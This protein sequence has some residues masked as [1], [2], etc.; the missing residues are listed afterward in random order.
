MQ[1]DE[2]PV[3]EVLLARDHPRD[4]VAM[5]LRAGA[6][7]TVRPGAYVAA[8]PELPPHAGRRR[9]A[10]AHIAA[11]REQL[12]VDV[13]VTHQSAALLWGLPLVVPSGPTHV[14]QQHHPGRNCADDV[15]R[16]VLQLAPHEVTEH[17]GFRTTTLERTVVDCA[18]SLPPRQAL[19]LA[20]AALHVGADAAAVRRCV[21]GMP[22]RRG[23]VGARAVLELADGGAESPGETLT[24]F[25][26]LRAGLPVPETQV[27]VTTH[28]GEY[29]SDL[30]W[31]AWRV[32]LEYDGVMKYGSAGTAVEAVLREK[33]RQEAIEEEGWRVLRV[34][35]SDLARPAALLGRIPRVA[36]PGALDGLRPRR[37]LNR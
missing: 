17:R 4:H 26:L 16:H 11:V 9:A 2:S 7:V 31:P 5:Q 22:G 13:T 24:R 21:D 30:G 8:A 37:A 18:L 36:P 19:I 27:L 6:W 29:W 23:V 33:R 15:A 25:L 14:N 1:R 3:P 32:L 28:L 10:L 34:T 12:D 35:S 20:D